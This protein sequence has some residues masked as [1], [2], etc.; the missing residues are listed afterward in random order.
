[1][2]TFYSHCIKK[3]RLF[4][5]KKKPCKNFDWKT[6]EVYLFKNEV[7]RRNNYGKNLCVFSTR[8]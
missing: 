3:I 5:E 4:R 6:R 2:S 1:M 7:E 8:I